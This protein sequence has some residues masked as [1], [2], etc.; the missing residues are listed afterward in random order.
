M[1]KTKQKALLILKVLNAVRLLQ[2]SPNLV[3]RTAIGDVTH[4]QWEARSE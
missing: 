2:S 1:Y 3:R 4:W